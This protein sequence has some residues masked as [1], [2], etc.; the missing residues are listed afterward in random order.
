MSEFN[1]SA[2]AIVFW[3]VV[4]VITVTPMILAFFRRRETE[5]TIRMAIEKGQSL[6]PQVLAK[7]LNPVAQTPEQEALNPEE[8]RFGGIVTLFVGLGMVGMSYF[9]GGKVFLGV[10]ALLG[11]IG[12]GLIVGAQ[13]LVAGRAG[14]KREP[15]A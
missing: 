3:I 7:M 2:V 15:R 11:C 1:W 12:L 6:D 9:F 8:I 13:L 4:L 5:K 10:A 14:A